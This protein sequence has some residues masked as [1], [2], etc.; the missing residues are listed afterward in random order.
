M[1]AF[2]KDIFSPT[3]EGTKEIIT[4][5]ESSAKTKALTEKFRQDHDD[6]HK[7]NLSAV[8]YQATFSESTNDKGVT[9]CWRKQENAQLT[10]LVVSDFDHLDENPR[11]LFVQW[12]TMLDFKKDRK[13]Y[14]IPVSK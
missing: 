10:G 2:Q 9:A 1:I 11:T 14:V 3:V 5:A 4:K 12:Q 7:R 8:C 6:Q 13:F